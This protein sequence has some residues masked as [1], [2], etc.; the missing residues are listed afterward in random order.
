M[1][2]DQVEQLLDDIIDQENQ[3]LA[4]DLRSG[5]KLTKFIYGKRKKRSQGWVSFK[6]NSKIYTIILSKDFE[7]NGKKIKVFN[8]EVMT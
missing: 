2:D 8:Q 3:E 5:M 7:N 6:I 1:I 4:G